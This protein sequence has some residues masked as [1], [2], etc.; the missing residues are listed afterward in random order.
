MKK[1][2][3]FIKKHDNIYIMLIFAILFIIPSFGIKLMLTDELW[4]F[5]NVYKMINGY[6]IYQECNVIITPLFFYIGKIL[7]K[8]IGANF[9]GFRI[10]CILINACVFTGIYMLFKSV[11][12]NKSK[13]F[14][15]T[16]VVLIFG[17]EIIFW[18]ANYNNLA[19]AFSIIGIVLLIKNKNYFWQGLIIF[20]VFMSKQNIGVYYAIGITIARLWVEK[21]FVKT[22]K[23]TFINGIT[24]ILLLSVYL[25]Y[26][27][28]NGSIYDFIDLILLGISEFAEKNIL[29]YISNMGVIVFQ[30][31]ILIF[32]F[33]II[34]NKKI[35]IEKEVK[36]NTRIL[37]SISLVFLLIEY[38]IFNSAHTVLASMILI[39]SLITILEKIVIRDVFNKSKIIHIATVIGVFI[40]MI[41]CAKNTICYI[42]MEFET[43]T[44]SPYYGVKIDDETRKSM[45]NVCNYIEKNQEKG[46]KTVILSYKSDLYLNMFKLSYN[47]FDLPFLGN[48]GGRGEQGLIEDLDKLKDT[49]ILIS[50]DEPTIQESEK[51]INYIKDNFN[52]A[53]EI[54]N[55]YI[56]ESHD[57]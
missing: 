7:L 34:T 25:I 50:K 46:K 32:G 37:L 2:G 52:L 28:L 31:V 10:Y 20:L 40:F 21:D 33:I 55:Y 19:I 8:V 15:Y 3:N 5:S 36:D 47:K 38:P 39:I 29:M 6:K 51:I 41:I 43:D 30:V 16:V 35:Q 27:Y 9:F 44:S 49:Y 12:I 13:S 17:N 57:M 24:T 18:G 42:S 56:Y 45:K 11:N 22:L 4:N 54:D 23:E 48:L 14:L 53:G 1:I 26:M